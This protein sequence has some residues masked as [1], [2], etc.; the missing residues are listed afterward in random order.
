M[1]APG[2]V[3]AFDA[4]LALQAAEHFKA[5]KKQR[6]AKEKAVDNGEY[7]KA[8]TTKR[9]AD[10][11]NRLLASVEGAVAKTSTPSGRELL[12]GAP[13]A[14]PLP[15]K[16]HE[17]IQHG[18]VTAETVTDDFLER[19]IGV[20]RDFLAIDFFAKGTVA[21]RAVCRIVTRLGGGRRGLGTGFMVTRSLLITNHHVLDVG[22]RR[23][24]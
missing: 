13:R 1:G 6:D 20:T 22:G 15:D 12:G 14:A 17:L 8:E 7:S 21:S 5:R 16:L 23:Q 18:P 4:D 9:M 11:A 10:R 2:D 24:T 3:P 19:V